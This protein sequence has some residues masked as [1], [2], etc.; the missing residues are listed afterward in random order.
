LTD[1][2][3][4]ASGNAGDI[5]NEYERAQH[6]VADLLNEQGQ[7]RTALADAQ[8]ALDETDEA[9]RVALRRRNDCESAMMGRTEPANRTPR[10]RASNGTGRRPGRPPKTPDSLST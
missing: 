7:R 6:E 8:S 9:L 5:A 10:V 4:V 3:T 1:I 2:L